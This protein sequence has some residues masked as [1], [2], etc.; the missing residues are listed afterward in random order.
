M[1]AKSTGGERERERK[2][3]GGTEERWKQSE[4]AE[5]SFRVEGWTPSVT[6][7]KGNHMSVRPVVY[8]TEPVCAPPSVVPASVPP[9]P[10]TVRASQ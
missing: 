9:H 3:E 8:A 6:S 2:G 10:A 5:R 4:Q 1:W 7:V